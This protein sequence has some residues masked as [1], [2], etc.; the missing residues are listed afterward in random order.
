MILHGYWRSGAAY[1][2]RIALNLKGVPYSQATH[3][4]RRDEQRGTA[5]AKLNPQ[6]MVPALEAEGAVLTQSVAIIE[7]IEEHYPSPPLLPGRLADRAHV[8]ALVAAITSDIHPLHNLR[9]AR[10]LKSDHGFD[11]DRV[12]AW[13]A[14]W[15]GEGFAAIEQ[16][17]GATGGRFAFGDEPTLADCCLVPQVYSAERFAVDLT[18]YPKLAAAAAAARALDAVAAAHPGRQPD[19]D[20]A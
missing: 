19:A 12:T 20:P 15:I 14:R 8:R 1:R 10:A 17:I 5:Y 11:D 2:V 18:P 16:M 4:L 13:N 7:W 3:D 6:L 9:I